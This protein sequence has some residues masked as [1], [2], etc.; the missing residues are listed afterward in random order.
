MIK[1]YKEVMEQSLKIV[2]E[3]LNSVEIKSADIKN[4]K[5]RKV[6]SA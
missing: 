4:V 3:F 1:I 5:L 2:I 6:S